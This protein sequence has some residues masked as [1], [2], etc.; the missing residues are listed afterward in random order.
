MARRDSQAS[1]AMAESKGVVVKPGRRHIVVAGTTLTGAFCQ[2]DT[3]RGYRYLDV[4]GKVMNQYGARFREM[5]V[6]LDG[7]RMW[8]SDDSFVE[9]RASVKQLVAAFTLPPTFDLLEQEMNGYM[10]DVT[11]IFEVDH[12]TRLGYRLQFV[13]PLDHD[14]TKDRQELLANIM[15]VRALAGEHDVGSF[16]V[17]VRFEESDYGISLSIAT[18]SRTDTKTSPSDATT[19]LLTE[20]PLSGVLFDV[21]FSSQGKALPLLNLRPLLRFGRKWAE[22]RLAAVI[23]QTVGEKVNA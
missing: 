6:G 12:A 16:N 19:D 1:G 21:D 11:G 20:L 9:A 23:A 22:T 17:A 14:R 3:V 5:T 18:V 8:G 7:L 13:W 2:V 10:R 4:A 15:H